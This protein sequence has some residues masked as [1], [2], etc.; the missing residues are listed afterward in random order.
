MPYV[1]VQHQP[2]QWVKARVEQ[3]WRYQ[4]RWRLAVYY[5]VG[6]QHYR[7]YEPTSAG[8]CQVPSRMTMIN[9]MQQPDRNS[10]SVITRRPGCSRR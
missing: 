7:V 10:P 2:G 3:R 8:R 6:L 1:M 5:Y 9:A 4:G